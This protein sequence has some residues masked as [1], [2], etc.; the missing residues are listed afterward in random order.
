M[1]QRLITPSIFFILL[2]SITLFASGVADANNA[3]TTNGT[4]PGTTPGIVLDVGA[5]HTI[6][7][8]H[9]YFS[10]PDGDT[11]TYTASSSD[12]TKVTVS[13]SNSNLTLTPVA[14]TG[15]ETVTITVTATD[16]GALS[17]SHTFSVKVEQNSAPT[18]VGTIPDKVA[19]IGGSDRTVEADDYFQDI[20]D[21]VLTY[22]AA[23]AD[24][25]IATVTVV[26][27][28]VTVTPVAVGSTTITITATD[29]KGASATQDFS[30]TVKVGNSAPVAQGTIPNDT[31]MV[32]GTPGQVNANLYFSDADTDPLTFT[33]TSSDTT[34]ATVSIEGENSEIVTTTA[35]A[36]GTVTI[37]ITATDTD[38]ATATQTY[39]V[40]VIPENN[41][42]E[43]IQGISSLPSVLLMVGGTTTINLANLFT[44]ADGDTL[45]YTA[46]SA[47]T[48][49]ATV[50]LS[51]A[52]LTVTAVAAGTTT[53]T[54][55][56]TDPGKA[57]AKLSGSVTVR[58]S[59]SAPTAINIPDQTVSANQTATIDLSA[60]FSDPD[61]DTLTYTASSSDTT[62]ATTGVSGATLTV[63]TL[64]AG[65][66]TISI[67]ATDPF[68]L[69]ASLSIALTINTAPGTADTTPTLSS[70]ELLQLSVLLTYDTLIINEL[71]NGSDDTTDWL[72]LR[73]V[74]SVDIPIDTW[75]LTIRTGDGTVIVPFPAGTVIPAGEV[76]LLTNTELATADASVLSVVAETFALP[77]TDF[78]L[79]LRDPIAFGD[80][81]GNYFQGERSETAPEL[82]VGTVWERTQPIGFGYRAEAWTES[83]ATDGLG[84]PGYRN[85]ASTADLNNDGV[86][87]MQDLQLVAS[88]FGTTD[89]TADLNADGIVN[90]LDLV[91]VASALTDI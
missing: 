81:A 75:Q 88:H 25:T 19:K 37:T 78:A 58:A 91:L 53:I 30:I 59:N 74:S 11:L 12:T 5:S 26:E 20:D 4:I 71:H 86:V 22:T 21:D 39:T 31:Q 77:Q 9:K 87:D 35:V 40:T 66:A 56:A 34:K 50:S 60:Y 82:T 80:I 23:S 45:T 48:T 68:G 51:S 84:T 15:D 61:G 46:S 13:I 14:A 16:P 52:T 79:I 89:P 28:K 57:W 27:S 10:D 83:T 2:L 70:Q 36:A 69:T 67:T 6:D 17:A 85:P 49:K 65:T 33:A 29:S 73:N 18:A 62:K 32:G 90:I 44:D 3:P 41:A 64:A 72:E 42:P 43:P 24:T 7:D 1:L 55:T 38:S 47:D 76:L 8:I 54:A 63:N